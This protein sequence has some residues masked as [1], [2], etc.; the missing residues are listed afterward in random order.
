MTMNLLFQRGSQISLL[1]LAAIGAYHVYTTLSKTGIIPLDTAVT[2]VKDF[3]RETQTNSKWEKNLGGTFPVEDIYKPGENNIGVMFWYCLNPNP[4][5]TP[6]FFL[7]AEKVSTYSAPTPGMKPQNALSLPDKCF[8]T[9]IISASGSVRQLLISHKEKGGQPA[10]VVPADAEGYTVN[11]TK[12]LGGYAAHPYCFFFEDNDEQLKN[13]CAQP[14]VTHVR[15][16]FGLNT[17]DKPNILRVILVAVDSNGEN[18]DGSES[19][20]ILQKSVPPPPGS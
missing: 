7:A 20:M 18:V 9:D 15:Y 12:E 2:L 17:N 1:L 16:Y 14:G 3:E 5:A 11:F 8:T 4:G 10:L 6:K 13:L 19:M